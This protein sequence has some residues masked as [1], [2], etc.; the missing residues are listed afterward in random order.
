V[1]AATEREYQEQT[2]LRR[3]EDYKEGVRAMAD[4]RTPE[5]KGS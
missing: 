1:Q 4:R 2:W 5:F 3:T